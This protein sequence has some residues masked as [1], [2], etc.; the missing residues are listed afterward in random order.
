MRRSGAG[1]GVAVL[2]AAAL[3]GC[4]GSGDSGPP[5]IADE[6]LA[7]SL[8]VA[9]QKR[10]DD[11]AIYGT[12]VGPDGGSCLGGE[13]RWKCKLQMQISGRVLDA[14][15]YAVLLDTEGCWVA[16][17]TGTDIGETGRV[18]RPTHPQILRGCVE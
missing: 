6:S 5:I 18:A 11:N 9:A 12:R 10:L 1:F 16:R 14:R 7:N 15:T 8:A 4:G 13:R 17:Q 2:C 3:A